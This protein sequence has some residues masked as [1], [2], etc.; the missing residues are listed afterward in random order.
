MTGSTPL[1]TNTSSR[2]NSSH[3]HEN[4]DPFIKT[5]LHNHTTLVLCLHWITAICGISEDDFLALVTAITKAKWFDKPH[6]QDAVAQFCLCIHKNDRYG[7]FCGL[8]N[9][10][11]QLAKE[12]PR[13]VQ[14]GFSNHPIFGGTW[15]CNNP[16]VIARHKQHGTKGIQQKPNIIYVRSRD[17]KAEGRDKK[18]LAIRMWTELMA[19]CEV[20]EEKATERRKIVCARMQPPQAVDR[21]QGSPLTVPDKTVS[22]TSFLLAAALSAIS[23]LTDATTAQPFQTWSATASAGS[24]S[25]KRKQ[26]G[27]DFK[28]LSLSS[29]SSSK[30]QR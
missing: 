12:E 10:V 4:V 16:I 11:L 15:I 25:H 29:S 20:K 2:K 30:R 26:K 28:D 23:G 24:S 3:K 18:G 1:K 14:L 7:P 6:I 19:F 8:A 17:L 22:G 27:T 9:G 5:D 13:L 21:P